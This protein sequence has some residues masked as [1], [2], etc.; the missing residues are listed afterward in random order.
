MRIALLI[1]CGFFLSMAVRARELTYK[2]RVSTLSSKKHINFKNY[3]VE[4]ID[5]QGL[6]IKDYISYKVLKESCTP[7]SIALSKIE[8]ADEELEDQSRKLRVFYEGCMEGTLGLG[9]LYQQY[10]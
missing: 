8:Q 9:H 5:P 1:V 7:L 3:L 2:E 6:P 4:Q 10:K